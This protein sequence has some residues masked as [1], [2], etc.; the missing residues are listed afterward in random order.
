MRINLQGR[1]DLMRT[2]L[3]MWV[4]SW[5]KYLRWPKPTLTFTMVLHGMMCII[6]TYGVKALP[7]RPQPVVNLVCADG[8]VG[9]YPLHAHVHG[10]AS[11]R[12]Y[13]YAGF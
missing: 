3:G 8:D 6:Y 10:R 2:S 12:V 7:P 5:V 1:V 13:I 11:T 9:E 4:C